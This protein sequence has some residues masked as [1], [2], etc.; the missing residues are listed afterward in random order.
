MRLWWAYAA[1]LSC[2]KHSFLMLTA[3]FLFKQCPTA[4]ITG[5]Y[6]DCQCCVLNAKIDVAMDSASTM[7]D[8]STSASLQLQVCQ[9]HRMMHVALL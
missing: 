4:N 6:R 2:T 5:S 7:L 9:M 1:E 8:M 3:F